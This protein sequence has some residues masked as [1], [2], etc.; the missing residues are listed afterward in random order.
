MKY[1]VQWLGLRGLPAFGCH[2]S[3]SSLTEPS[4]SIPLRELHTVC[5]L[6]WLSQE[7]QAGVTLIA[8]G[9]VWEVW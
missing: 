5:W 6:G 8:A 4:E 2:L 7:A 1:R 9:F 3:S